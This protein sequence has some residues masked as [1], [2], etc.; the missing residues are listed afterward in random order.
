[1]I[2]V[3]FSSLRHGIKARI[4]PGRAILPN[5]WKIVS[6]YVAPKFHFSSYP[7]HEIVVMPALSPTMEAG[8]I[9][10]WKINE[11]QEFSAGDVLCEVETDKATVDF[12]AQDGGIIAKH[13]VASGTQDVPCGSPIMV[14]VQNIASVAAFKDF[15]IAP[16]S[17]TSEK[18]VP[19]A[20]VAAS[21]PIP[22]AKP[23]SVSEPPATKLATVA[24]N[25]TVVPAPIPLTPAMTKPTQSDETRA[26]VQTG[27]TPPRNLSS[28]RSPLLQRMLK[29]QK[30]YTDKFGVCL[31]EISV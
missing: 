20:P 11:G 6:C 18:P 10:K 14:V 8:N 9:G 17:A 12:E 19:A 30:E 4:V 29:D 24:E 13:L 28:V 25:A 21:V 7:D 31:L 16:T 1:M 26:S 2:A 22:E 5:A 27:I 23:V 3:S 15:A